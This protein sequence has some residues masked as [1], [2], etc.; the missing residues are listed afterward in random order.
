MGAVISTFP[1]PNEL[2]TMKVTGKQLRNL[3]EHGAGFKQRCI[4]GVQRAGDEV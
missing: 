3:M 2:A 1:F 4:A